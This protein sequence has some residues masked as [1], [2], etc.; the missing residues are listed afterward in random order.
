MPA[1]RGRHHRGA[2]ILEAERR[3]RLGLGL[4]DR[5][6]LD[7]L[8][9]AVEP[10][11]LGG[12][13][14]GFRGVLAQQQPGAEIG[15]PDPA[16]GIDARAEHEAEM[17]GLRRPGEARGVDQRGEPDPLAPPHRDQALGDEGAVEA[18]ERHHVGDGAERDEVDEV[19]QVGLRPRRIPEAAAAQLAVDRDDGQEHEADGGEMA[20][21]REIVVPVRI[22]DH[23]LGQLR[24]DLVMIDDD[25]VEAEPRGFG[26]RLEARGAAVDGDEELGAALG[27]TTDRLD[28]RPIAFE[29]AVGNMEQ[30]VEAAAAQEAREQRRRG[31]TVDVVV[32]E[33]GDGFPTLH[34]I[35]DAHRRDRHVGEDIGV[36]HQALERRVEIEAHRIRLDL[37]AGDDAGEE[38]RHPMALH[39]RKRPCIAALV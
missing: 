10:V 6:H 21:R 22:D 5:R 1:R 39:D 35:G 29:D 16:A 19:E 7:R 34:G 24:V 28:V 8:P 27:E 13:R 38:L 23:R 17:P 4:G 36:G 31:R 30:R 32:A 3:H 18:D 33:D 20:E 26:E 25:G 12:H 11:E 14:R 9:F 2:A 15:P 37:A